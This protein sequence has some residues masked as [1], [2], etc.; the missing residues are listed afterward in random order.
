MNKTA[1]FLTKDLFPMKIDLNHFTVEAQRKH[2]NRNNS[3]YFDLSGHPL[4]Y[5]LCEYLIFRGTSSPA[6]TLA[7][8]CYAFTTLLRYFLAASC[9]TL[10]GE[11]FAAYTTWLRAEKAPRTQNN[12][13]EGTRRFYGNCALM[14]MDWLL[15]VGEVGVSDVYD[16][17][18]R[19]QKA[20]RGHNARQLELMRLMAIAPDDYVRLIKAIRLEYEEC[21]A[22]LSQS[23]N[24]QE[25]YETT[26]PLLPFSML[27]GAQLALRS[28]EFNYLD[29]RDLRGDRLLLNPPNKE[30]SEVWL[31]PSVMASLDLAQ[32]WMA[33]YRPSPTGDEP[34]LVFPL[35]N[36]VRKSSLG[37]FDS[38]LLSNSLARFYKKYFKLIAPDGRPYLYSLGEDDDSNPIPFSLSF[39][40]FRSAAITEAARHET[41]PTT[42]M[43]FARHACYDTTLKYYIRETHRQWVTNVAALLAPSAELVRVSLDNKIASRGEEEVAQAVN[44]TVRGG[45]CDQAVSGDRSCRRATDCRLCNFFRIHISK[46]EFFVGERESALEQAASLQ[47]EQ[48]LH[49]DAQNLREFAALNEAIINRIDDHLAGE[50]ST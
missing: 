32:Q 30:Q 37:R 11:S 50:A 40:N 49:R 34:L 31:P 44:A 1:Q 28:E 46:R 29:V 23:S 45:H 10:N 41:N 36:G 14:F 13:S 39:K 4:S 17:R 43:R 26:F 6:A 22:L 33:R 35:Q 27:A 7:G 21:K 20:F 42:V 8:Y 38:L 2:A 18:R 16:A 47:N 19:Y 9:K 3:F 15:D 12:Y 24:I 5:L 25:Q 48:G